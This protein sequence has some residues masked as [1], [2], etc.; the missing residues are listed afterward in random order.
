MARSF[1]SNSLVLLL[2]LAGAGCAAAAPLPPQASALNR[3]GA[4]ALEQGDLDTAEARLSVALEYSPRFVEALTNLGLVEVQ[5]GNFERAREL[6]ERA[7]RINADVAQPHHALGVLAERQARVDRASRHYQDALKVDPGFAPARANYA[8]LLFEAGMLE[9]ARSQ[10]LRLV[11]A[12][13]HEPRGFEGL[14]ECL[15]HLGR[16]SEADAVVARGLD[17]HARS[18]ALRILDARRL[19]HEGAV[20]AAI[21]ALVPLTEGVG[22]YSVAA[23]AWL[24]LAESAAGDT[25]AA[26]RAAER[27]AGLNPADPLAVYAL[28]SVLTQ[29]GDPRAARWSSRA[30]AL[31]PRQARVTRGLPPSGGF[32]R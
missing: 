8:R 27:A 23:L 31:A 5:R 18:P 30:E 4:E 20:D 7:R 17:R 10:F 29:T 3:A 9:H 15:L 28:A 19:L 16:T 22:D 6:L 24:A 13:P 2:A 14:A 1:H 26:L 21:D 32:P 11:E 25:Q 12:A